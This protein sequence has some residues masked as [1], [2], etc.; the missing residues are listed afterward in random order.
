MLLDD[1]QP[2]SFKG[3]GFL[4]PSDDAEEGRN[5]ILH[6]YPDASHR[7]AEDNG[8]I[9]G[10]FNIR[11]LLHGPDLPGQF[12]KLRSA[13]T[14][15]GPGVLKHPWYG[16]QF[17]QLDGTFRVRREDRQSGILEIDIPFCVTGPP[18]LPGLVSGVAALVTGLAGDAVTA[19]FDEFVKTYGD[20]NS[21]RTATV[22]A[23]A[24]TD[25]VGTLEDAF[26]QA[27]DVPAQII[28]RKD[29]L[30]RRS[31]RLAELLIGAYR[32][33][34]GDQTL[35]DDKLVSGFRDAFQMSGFVRDEADVIS[36]D[37]ADL[38]GR[39][40]SLIV[41]ADTLRAAAFASM[42]E[43]IAG[44]DFTTADDV[45]R[46]ETL[47]AE[48]FDSIQG[49]ELSGDLH[50]QLLGIYTATSEVLRD[51]SVRLPRIAEFDVNNVPASILAYQL[52][53]SDDDLN[54]IVSLNLDQDPILFAGNTNALSVVD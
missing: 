45:E 16:N 51:T 10:K 8:L 31:D 3:A 52:Y 53:E 47:L 32:E 26:Q 42:A 18:A 37:T 5:T 35:T 27:T 50:S 44:R 36:P 23:D 12:S 6:E 2:A 30:V 9:P 13:L 48:S 24:L 29:L 11:A 4:V 40:I 20:P 25:V 39:K 21:L 38:S 1:L 22:I 17:V 34:F 54:T 46:Y 41:L 43:A 49:L 14:S 33:P 7:Y 28:A 15:P 19:L